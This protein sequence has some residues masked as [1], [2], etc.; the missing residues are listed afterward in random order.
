MCEQLGQ[1]CFN[2]ENRED[3][4]MK[5]VEEVKHEQDKQA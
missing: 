2:L 5:D 1:K 3:V 4:Q